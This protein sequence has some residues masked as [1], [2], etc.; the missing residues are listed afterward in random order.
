MKCKLV[1]IKTVGK[2]KS[3][4][5]IGLY[6]CD[7]GNEKTIRESMVG[8]SYTH[9]KS[10]GCLSKESKGDAS[11]LSGTRIYRIWCSM[12]HRCLNPK[13]VYYKYYGGRGITMCDRWLK[14]QNFHEDMKVGYTNKLSIDRIDPS[15]N[16][17]K[18]NCKWSS[19][20]EQQRNRRDNLYYMY[21]GKRTMLVDIAKD[22][23]ILLNTLRMR[24]FKH[25]WPPEKAFTIST[26]GFHKKNI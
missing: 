17:C 16:Y 21:K 1:K 6:K 3:G 14:F 12:R 13:H 24:L 18:E 8:N 4:H 26:K 11:G 15:G 2:D 22:T 7:C 9:T 23:G 5:K 25:N 20:K 19:T 10:C